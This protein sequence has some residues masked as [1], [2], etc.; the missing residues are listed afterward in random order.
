VPCE[1]AV[2]RALRPDDGGAETPLKS[3]LGLGGFSN[4]EV[5]LVH[6]LI[7]VRFAPDAI[8][9]RVESVGVA[10]LNSDVLWNFGVGAV[11]VAA[12][13]GDTDVGIGPM[14][15]R[16]ARRASRRSGEPLSEVVPPRGDA[17]ISEESE[18]RDYQER[19]YG[20]ALR[21]VT[22]PLD[23]HCHERSDTERHERD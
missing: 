12:N 17:D 6:Q 20:R 1:F 19:R 5:E 21:A 10:T 11:K 14:A 23:Q 22:G 9:V 4:L 8:S 16:I 3:D 7:R 13:G 18:R 2:R 15:V